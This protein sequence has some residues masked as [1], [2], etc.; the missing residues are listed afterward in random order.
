M[1]FVQYFLYGCVRSSSWLFLRLRYD[2]KVTG[3]HFVP[4][5]GTFIVASNHVSFLD[6][7][8]I[9][10]SCPRR[11]VFMAREDLW[12]NPFMAAYM[13]GMRVVPLKRGESDIAAVRMAI[14]SLKQGEPIGLF[15]EGTRQADGRLSQAKRGVGLL[16]CRAKVPIVPVVVQGTYEALPRDAKRL[17]PSKIRV[18][19]G[20]PIPYT[21]E[22]VSPGS[23]IDSRDVVIRS[24]GDS[25][26]DALSDNSAKA[27]SERHEQLAQ[28]LTRRWQQLLQDLKAGQ[29]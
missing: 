28:A 17:Q 18:A 15:P 29:Q 13:W 10:A 4:K 20:E 21:I 3:R 14:R 6:P 24:S 8:V 9:G 16:A 27:T 25:Q 19:F 2:L 23:P 1:R 26:A 7:L 22:A 11:L 12:K 5:K